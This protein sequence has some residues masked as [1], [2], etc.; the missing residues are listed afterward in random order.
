MQCH[1]QTGAALQSQHSPEGD[2]TP[3]SVR[4]GT[5]AAIAAAIRG[6]IAH[7][8]TEEAK[9]LR[10]TVVGGV[11]RL[12]G[13]VDV[14]EKKALADELAWRP[15]GV[16]EVVNEIVVGPTTLTAGGTP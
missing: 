13:Q 4:P 15:V 14:A 3:T 10:V 11:V 6:D 2:P 5:D 9:R 12:Q 16:R 1:R 7:H 8:L